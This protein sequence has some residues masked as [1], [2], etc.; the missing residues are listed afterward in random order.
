M[1]RLGLL[2]SRKPARLADSSPGAFTVDSGG[3][4][5]HKAPYAI[6]PMNWKVA[7]ATNAILTTINGQPRCRA[8]P[9]QT[10]PSHAPSATLVAR[11]LSSESPGPESGTP[12]FAIGAAVAD[13]GSV[14]VAGDSISSRT[15]LAG[16]MG[17]DSEW[18]VSGS[19]WLE[20]V[21]VMTQLADTARRWGWRSLRSRPFSWAGA[22][23]RCAPAS[24]T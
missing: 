6:T 7:R 18:R 14:V 12:S 23:D 16:C 17:S 20:S 9:V 15:G 19:R 4:N 10:P 3:S 21:A 5:S 1:R 24:Y 11:G 8:S 2:S 13:V 22:G